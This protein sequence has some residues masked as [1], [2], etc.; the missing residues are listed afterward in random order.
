[1]FT[2]RQAV[3]IPRLHARGHNVYEIKSSELVTRAK[4][5]AV[6]NP[7]RH[8]FRKGKV[9]RTWRPVQLGA[10]VD[11]V[12]GALVARGYTLGE[13]R[14]AL[15]RRRRGVLGAVACTPPPLLANWVPPGAQLW[16]GAR[17][18]NDGFWSPTLFSG[19]SYPGVPGGCTWGEHTSGRGHHQMSRDDVAN[20]LLDK[21]ESNLP[22]AKE[23]ERVLRTMHRTLASADHANIEMATA[24]VYPW[25]LVGPVAA[26]ARHAVCGDAQAH[27]KE[28]WRNNTLGVLVAV[29]A[30]AATRSVVD[31]HATQLCATAYVTG[32]AH[33]RA[34]RS[35]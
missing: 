2:A 31:Q 33:G 16:V 19:Y 5:R 25:R 18:S 4:L 12:C 6:P 1:M 9:A 11:A 26:A 35:T 34:G 30:A 28:P 21:L 24:Q 7:K 14:W 17:H 3:G 10:W 27:A 15:V 22:E 23:F 13:E 20:T 8:P 29:G 32:N